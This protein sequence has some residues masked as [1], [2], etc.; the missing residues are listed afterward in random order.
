MCKHQTMKS[1]HM[2]STAKKDHWT[3]QSQLDIKVCMWLDQM[4][5]RSMY[6]EERSWVR[7]VA[8]HRSRLDSM[9]CRSSN[10]HAEA[11]EFITAGPWPEVCIECDV[12]WG[13]GCASFAEAIKLFEGQSFLWWRVC[14]QHCSRCDFVREHGIM[15]TWKSGETSKG[16]RAHHTSRSTR[17]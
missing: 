12:H 7:S 4:R 2:C 11:A 10:E 9:S 14:A 15:S 3:E 16:N 1:T 8:V 17:S 5:K 6:P 13:W